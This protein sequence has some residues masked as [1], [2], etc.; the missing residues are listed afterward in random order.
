MWNRKNKGNSK[1]KICYRKFR[2]LFFLSLLILLSACKSSKSF[3]TSDGVATKKANEKLVSDILNAE[4]NYKTISGKVALELIPVNKTSG[5]KLNSQ[6]KI[7]RNEVIQLSMRAPF[8]NTEVFRLDISPDSI[9]V[10][11]RLGKRFAVESI[12]DIESSKNIQFNYQNLQA[13]FTN[14]LFFPGKEQVLNSDFNQFLISLN[15][16]KYNLIAKD[17]QGMSYDFTVDSSDRIIST[18]I[19]GLKTYSLDWKYSNF[20]QDVGYVYPTKMDISV[21]AG[22][23]KFTFVISYSSLDIDKDLKVDRNLP[24]NYKRVSVIEIIKSYIK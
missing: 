11:D 10:I 6:L 12:K 3:V 24:S 13:L 19:A 2:V 23:T 5:M 15:S 14:A 17:R 21:N 1:L 7:V 22:K 9:S 18:K 16:G 8:I 20:I 4:T